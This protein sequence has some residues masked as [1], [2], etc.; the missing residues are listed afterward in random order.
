VE[1]RDT[2]SVVF[3]DA[4]L[5]IYL[6][7]D[8]DE[9]AR[10]RHAELIMKGADTGVNDV[11]TELKTRDRRDGTRSVSPLVI[12]EH[13]VVVDTTHLSFGEVVGKILSLARERLTD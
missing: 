11:L 4:D 12:P 6:D 8:P 5:K 2:G 9:R 10:R 7:A 13:A 3:P 1:G